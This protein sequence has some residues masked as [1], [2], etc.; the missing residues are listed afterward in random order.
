MLH[1]LAEAAGWTILNARCEPLSVTAHESRVFDVHLV[2]EAASGPKSVRAVLKLYHRELPDDRVRRD[3]DVLTRLAACGA[4]VPRVLACLPQERALLLEHAGEDTL[5]DLLS[6]NAVPEHLWCRVVR[7]VAKLHQVLNGGAFAV[8]EYPE[9]SF[10]QQ[11]RYDWAMAGL[12]KWV[13]WEPALMDRVCQES[14]AA[15]LAALARRLSEWDCRAQLIW[16]DCNPKN[17]VVKDGTP[18]LIDLQ[19]KQSSPMI[20]LVLLLTFADSPLSYVPRPQA[21]GYLQ[22]YWSA[23]KSQL[24]GL[25]TLPEFLAWYDQEL[26]WRILVYGGNLLQAR[27][28]RLACWSEVCLAMASDLRALLDA[29]IR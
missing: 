24:P 18:C 5:A 28:A 14:A 12:A 4:G 13:A 1:R 3:G 22:E 27:Q 26:L 9:W 17:V 19:L 6:R 11:Q 2:I 21:H 20:D 10:D 8:Q 25:G 16:G 29:I 15:A 7:E 23:M